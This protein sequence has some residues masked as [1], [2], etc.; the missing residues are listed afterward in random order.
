[1]N[2]VIDG[3]TFQVQKAYPFGISRVWKEILKRISYDTVT[4]LCRG[5][6]PIPDVKNIR[7]RIIAP[8]NPSQWGNDIKYLQSICQS[9]KA[10]W[11]LSTYY[12][13]AS[14][15]S[16]MPVYDMIPERVPTF[17][18]TD[19]WQNLK[20]QCIKSA[21]KYIAISESTKRDLCQL[22][23]VKPEDVT[24]MYLGATFDQRALDAEIKAFKAKYGLPDRYYLM[25][26]N[27]HLYKNGITALR[28]HAQ[29]VKQGDNSKIVT[30]G[31]PIL[32]TETLFTQNMV[33]LPR[34]TDHDLQCAYSGALCLLYPSLYEGFGL[35]IIEA[36]AC[37]CPVIST[38]SSSMIEIGQG[39]CHFLNDPLDSNEF[40]VAMSKYTTPQILTEGFS[41]AK[42]YTWDKAATTMTDVFE[43]KKIPYK[44]LHVVDW[45][46]AKSEEEQQRNL[47]AQQT[48]QSLIDWQTVYYDSA[49]KQRSSRDIG[50]NRDL[51]FVKDVINFACDKIG[52]ND[53]TILTNTDSCLVTETPDVLKELV[54]KGNCFYSSRIDVD[55]TEN[56][57]SR[58]QIAS[59]IAYVG[60]D[61]FVFRKSWWLRVRANF[62]DLLMGYEGW[63][64]VM[65]KMMED[66]NDHAAILPPVVYHKRHTPFW[67]TQL[68]VNKGQMH[69]RTL[70]AQWAR[71]NGYEHGI[72]H[73]PDVNG[74]LFKANVIKIKTPIP[75]VTPPKIPMGTKK[76]FVIGRTF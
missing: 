14:M 49:Q 30:V 51:P 31:C 58:Q 32:P 23:S 67:T 73:N 2:I 55:T 46:E 19:F 4:L 60:T 33:V 22:F 1:M 34:V 11:F 25:A 76:P 70:A 62:P 7:K 53:W 44:L 29:L 18:P 16:I 17:C 50:D 69:N 3:I 74:F 10:D 47:K 71:E 38:R 8:Y 43:E 59:H 64:F 39:Y 28:A 57:L 66:D 36:M 26:G 5:E 65:S 41:L 56:P 48:W 40:S 61:L 75:I 20:K 52:S 24:V 13:T 27:R 68:I 42:N 63:D 21:S 35:P 15:P 72:M 45:Y 37:G 12:T 6:D 54:Y 9:E